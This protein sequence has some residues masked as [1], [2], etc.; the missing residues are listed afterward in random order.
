MWYACIE[1]NAMFKPDSQVF[2]LTV[3]FIKFKDNFRPWILNCQMLVEKIA[4]RRRHWRI[5]CLHLSANARPE[6]EA[7][8][9]LN[10]EEEEEYKSLPDADNL[11]ISLR[12]NKEFEANW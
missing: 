5:F 12:V 7:C 10:L 2:L 4:A 8:F 3:S 1:Y 9:A 6:V 11:S